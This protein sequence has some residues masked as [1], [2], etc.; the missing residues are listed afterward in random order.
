M[1]ANKKSAYLA[2]GAQTSPTRATYTAES[3]EEG[4]VH[5]KRAW[6]E[7]VWVQGGVNSQ[8]E[9]GNNNQQYAERYPV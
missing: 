6:A 2:G 1:V 3:S 8:R 5:L 9:K 7:M 4:G